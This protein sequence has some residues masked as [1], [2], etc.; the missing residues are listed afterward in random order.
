MFTRIG[1]ILVHETGVWASGEWLA[2]LL[3]CSVMPAGVEGPNRSPQQE[4]GMGEADDPV[5]GEWKRMSLIVPKEGK[6]FL[7]RPKRGETLLFDAKIE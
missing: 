7:L 3:S 5:I 4:Q 2:A 6:N 1:A